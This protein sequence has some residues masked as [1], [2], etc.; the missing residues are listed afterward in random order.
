MA[1]FTFA[2]GEDNWPLWTPD[3]K[4]IVYRSSRDGVNYDINRKAA[5]GT[6]EVEKLASWPNLPGP[7]TWSQDAKTLLSWD[8]NRSPMQSDISMLSLEGGHARVPLLH[9]KYYEDHPQISPDGQWLAYASNESGRSEVYVRPF[10]DVNKSQVKISI[11]GGYGP[12]WSPDGR[13]LF[14]RNLESVLSV[15]A[16]PGP[17]FKYGKPHVLF[18]G[19]Y[20][21]ESVGA[22]VLPNWDIHPDGKRF[23]MMKEIPT[24]AEGPQRIN[25][26]LNWFEELK[27][28]VP[29]K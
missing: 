17:I 23:L 21:S 4:R 28:R 27:Q 15:S 12:L 6:G 5:D 7:L 8:L 1:R 26:V 9:E 20:L 13:E 24:A 18:R 22:G 10:P 19:A 14:Y 11:D 29:T 16:E 2:E 3:G 25:I